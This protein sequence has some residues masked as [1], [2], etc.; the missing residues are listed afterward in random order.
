[1]FCGFTLA[2]WRHAANNR[3]PPPPL[4]GNVGGSNSEA[5]GPEFKVC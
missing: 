4:S 2:A 5:L 1:M 3:F